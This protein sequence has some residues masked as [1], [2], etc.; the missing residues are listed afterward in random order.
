MKTLKAIGLSII[1]I[2]SMGFAQAGTFDLSQTP[3]EVPQGTIANAVI[4]LDDSA[5]MEAEVITTG[6]D[7]DGMMLYDQPFKVTAPSVNELVGIPTGLGIE[8]GSWLSYRAMD[9]NSIAA[10]T[11]W[12]F[13][14]SSFN[15]LYYDP[16][17]IYEP[18]PGLSTVWNDSDGKFVPYSGLAEY[19]QGTR[20]SPTAAL[21]GID[22]VTRPENL[23]NL[24]NTGAKQAQ[25]GTATTKTIKTGNSGAISKTLNLYW[26]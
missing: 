26:S 21:Y 10:D 13:R 16:E 14:N 17:E 7:N 24:L 23:I 25:R 11:E 22:D 15:P 1:P 9:S 20:S 3:M 2:L 12:R 5:S 8:L 19:L 6:Y 18:W 4:I